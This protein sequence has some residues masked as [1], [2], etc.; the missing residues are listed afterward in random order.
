MCTGHPVYYATGSDKIMRQIHSP[1]FLTLRRKP[2]SVS[3]IRA[4][5]KAR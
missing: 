2:S 5:A 3:G 4:N 1:L